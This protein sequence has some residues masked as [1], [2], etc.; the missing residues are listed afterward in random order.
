[1][2]EIPEATL[3]KDPKYAALYEA[4]R[5]WRITH[6]ANHQERLRYAAELWEHRSYSLRQISKVCR[7]SSA[8]LARNNLRANAGGGR[9]EPESLTTLM[10]IRKL[11]LTKQKV[12]TY[13]IQQAVESGTSINAVAKLT[14]AAG[15]TMYK[16]AKL[17]T[18]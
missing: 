7:I 2:S 3:L 13:M 15:G 6:I 10:I 1:M 16:S 8:T 14:G 4:R 5:L 11:V 12:P 17:T 9:F 18:T